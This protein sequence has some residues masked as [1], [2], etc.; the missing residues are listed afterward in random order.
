M[1]QE[2]GRAAVNAPVESNSL[3]SGFLLGH[4]H[5]GEFNYLSGDIFHRARRKSDVN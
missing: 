5:R 1:L 2:G 3:F 4:P